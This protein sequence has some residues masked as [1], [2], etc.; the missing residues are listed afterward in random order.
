ML[1]IFQSRKHLK[2]RKN[3]LTSLWPPDKGMDCVRRPTSQTHPATHTLPTSNRSYILPASIIS[4]VLQV[5]LLHYITC[6]L[7][8]TL[9]LLERAHVVTEHHLV[10]QLWP[11]PTYCLRHVAAAV[12][13]EIYIVQT[14]HD[15]VVDTLELNPGRRPCGTVVEGK[16]TEGRPAGKR[17]WRR[18]RGARR[19][20][21]RRRW[22]AYCPR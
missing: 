11:W 15:T 4:S 2:F 14:N 5:C 12:L 8:I 7:L 1:P 17:C 21:G 18:R 10:E 6:R 20:G 22:R 16:E 13:L 3:R 9:A 19:S